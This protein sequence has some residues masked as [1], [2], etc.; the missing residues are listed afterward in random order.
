[1]ILKLLGIQKF[2]Y[3]HCRLSTCH[4]CVTSYYVIILH[5]ICVLVFLNIEIV[6][7]VSDVVGSRF[8]FRM[9]VPICKTV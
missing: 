1:M 4:L 6:I 9:L 5:E 3:V 8:L 7:K 2:F